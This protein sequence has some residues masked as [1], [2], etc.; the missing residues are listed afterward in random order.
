[1]SAVEPCLCG[2]PIADCEHLGAFASYE[3]KARHY[4]AKPE[5]IAKMAELD[6]LSTRA[7]V[8]QA[9]EIAKVAQAE[10]ARLPLGDALRDAL[11][12]IGIALAK[13]ALLAGLD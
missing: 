2:K 3:E 7:G 5:R 11:A 4:R 12:I 9:I 1:M 8:K 13:A 10:A 6:A